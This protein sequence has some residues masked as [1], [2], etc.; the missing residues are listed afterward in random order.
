MAVSINSKC[1]FDG[2]CEQNVQQTLQWR[3]PTSQS[4]VTCNHNRAIDKITD[5]ESEGNKQ[6]FTL[7]HSVHATKMMHPSQL[8][9]F[10]C[11]AKEEISRIIQDTRNILQNCTTDK[12]RQKSVGLSVKVT[13][14]NWIRYCEQNNVDTE[15][16]SIMSNMIM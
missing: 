5:M 14:Q 3:Q 6:L 10:K 7:A 4:T 8:I 11:K 15:R 1:T 12:E 13:G 2:R 16:L 9:W